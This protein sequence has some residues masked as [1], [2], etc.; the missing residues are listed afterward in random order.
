MKKMITIRVR[1]VATL[2]VKND[3]EIVSEPMRDF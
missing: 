2:E 3:L 1:I